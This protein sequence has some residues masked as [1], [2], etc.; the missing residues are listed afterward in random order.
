LFAARVGVA[1]EAHKT[2]PEAARRKGAQGVVR[3]R[4]RVAADGRLLAAKL[5]SSSGSSLLDHA[6]L[7]LAASV[8]PQDNAARREFEFLLAVK[9]S[10][11][12]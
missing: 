5:A 6:A 2:Y 4:L 11:S 12:D 1:I 10:L 7:E 3:L 9:Y 8:F